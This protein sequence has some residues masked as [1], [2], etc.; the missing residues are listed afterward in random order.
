MDQATKAKIGSILERITEPQSYLSVAELG[1]VS[2]VSLVAEERTL[3]ISMNIG[4]PRFQCPAHS[5][6]DEGGHQSERLLAGSRI[7]RVE[8]VLPE[9]CA[10]RLS[11]SLIMP[12]LDRIHLRPSS[13]VKAVIRR[14]PDKDRPN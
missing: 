10:G 1:L 7:A 9:S 6:L 3:V 8:A 11:Q 13:C 5:G 12:S 14:P 4:T 2:R